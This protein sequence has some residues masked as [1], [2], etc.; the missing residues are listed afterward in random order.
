MFKGWR[1]KLSLRLPKWRYWPAVALA[2]LSALAVLAFCIA[3]AAIPPSTQGANAATNNKFYELIWAT[4]IS[5]SFWTAVFTGALTLSTVLLWRATKRLSEGAETQAEDTRKSL[6][7]AKQSADAAVA[8]Q[9]PWLFIETKI[10]SPLTFTEEGPSIKL[11][12]EIHNVGNTPATH[13]QFWPFMLADLA[14]EKET[15]M[16]AAMGMSR[17]WA[18]KTRDAP[19]GLIAFPGVAPRQEQTHTIW[20]SFRPNLSENPKFD[21]IVGI[22]MNYRFVG[23]TGCTESG[24]V[25]KLMN[26]D[27]EGAAWIDATNGPVSSDELVCE[28]HTLWDAAS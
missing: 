10:L 6:A 22:V 28:R 23:G 4:L 12:F 25:I 13:V 7:I 2:L 5:A 3:P 14:G 19:L 24:F 18:D 17:I 1:P 9:R 27:T 8:A 20:E 16:E 15:L 21:L 11:G 26:C